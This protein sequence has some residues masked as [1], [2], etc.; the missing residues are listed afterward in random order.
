MKN[1]YRIMLGRKSIY[2]DECHKD[3]FIGTGWL[4]DINLTGKLPDNWRDFN[5]VFIPIYIEKDP[6][7][8]KVAA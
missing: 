3:N 6:G 8:S 4:D 1:Y 5:K 2:A 7:T